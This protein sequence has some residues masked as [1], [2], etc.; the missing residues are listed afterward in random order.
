MGNGSP[1]NDD[2]EQFGPERPDPA[3]K[4]KATPM[5]RLHSNWMA[6]A[7]SLLL[8]VGGGLYLWLRSATQAAQQ[9]KEV[10]AA[11]S[12]NIEPEIKAAPKAATEAVSPS[13]QMEQQR[14]Q[15]QEAQ[16]APARPNTEEIAEVFAVD[17][18]GQGLRRKRRLAS[19]ANS[20]RRRQ[21]E[22]RLAAA[23]VDTIET[24]V[25]DATTGSY[26]S[27]T[28]VV[29]RRR[30]GQVVGSA[31]RRA[32]SGA[33]RGIR[34]GLLPATDTD[35]T[36]FETDPDV[37]SMLSTSP[38]ETRA[39]YE[40]MTG[41]RY[42]DPNVAAQALANRTGGQGSNRPDGFNTV[43]VGNS[44][45]MMA[46]SNQQELVPDVFFKCVINGEQKV[47]TGSVVL[48][49]LQED[50]VVSGVTFPKNSIFAGIASV[51][52][53]NVT[54][55]VNR[56]GPT[57]VAAQIYD[58][59]YMPG[60]MIDPVKRVA[61]DASLAGQDLQQQSTQEVSTAIDRSASAANSVTGVAGRVA[62]GVLS[63]PKTRTKLRDVLLPDGYPI[64][65]TTAAAG[66]MG[67]VSAS[68][69]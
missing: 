9:N 62:L 56:L 53:N 13:V 5:E 32:S 48:L 29:P 36:P 27:E 8:L 6:V 16:N 54:L 38:P 2:Q 55:E 4:P 30:P 34:A 43:K 35:G 25:Q 46:Q 49:R 52:T 47:R 26:R 3:D 51:G 57:R 66:Q 45:R 60:I 17:T 63:R 42:R 31:A 44:S 21:E 68:G 69:R 18:T 39:A 33:A 64:L 28:L 67:P 7:F 15:E 59:N 19:A 14:R 1:G 58:Y 20:A 24:T 22:A 61:K 41:K 10:V 40:R 37:L 23:D 50:A 12:E 11:A 65:I